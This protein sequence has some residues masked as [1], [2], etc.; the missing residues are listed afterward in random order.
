MLLTVWLLI[1]LFS[2]EQWVFSDIFY[3]LLYFSTEERLEGNGKHCVASVETS[4]WR[5]EVH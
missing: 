3:V 5:L 2:N 4:V 1:N